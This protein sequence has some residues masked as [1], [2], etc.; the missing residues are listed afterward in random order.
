MKNT[1]IKTLLL[2][3]FY[4]QISEAQEL[5]IGQNQ[6][7][8]S[9]N[10]HNKTTAL[11]SQSKASLHITSEIDLVVLQLKDI[12]K[13]VSLT[14]SFDFFQGLQSPFNPDVWIYLERE[15][16]GGAFKLQKINLK[17]GKQTT[18]INKKNKN[19][20]DLVLKP[21]AWTKDPNKFFAEAIYLDAAEEHEG[22]FIYNI[23]TNEI[24]KLPISF[25]YT[26][27][28]LLSPQRDRF[29]FSGS[30]K[31]KIDHLHDI[32]DHIYE[33]NIE[34]KTTRTII[35]SKGKDIDVLGWN[36]DSEKNKQYRINHK[37]NLSYYL[38]WDFGKENCVSRHGTPGPTGSH[39]PVGQCGF[40][41]PGGHHGYHAIDFATS[42]SGD[43]NVRAS[44]AGTVSFS[45]ISGSLSSGYGR[46]VIIRHSDGTRTYYAH[47]K[48]LLVNQ[49][50]SV[51]KGQVI[52]LEGTTGGS[53][54]D[55]IHFEWRAAGG[56]SPTSGSFV[57]AGQPRQN[58][59]YR[60]QNTFGSQSDTQAPTTSITAVGGNT[61]SSDFT[62]NYLDTDNIGV[63]RRF[64]Q[65][66]E[67]YN[68]N[69]YANRG[70]GFFNDN[71]N[72]FYSGYTKGAGNWA[73]NNGHLSQSNITLDNTK[74][75]TFL[76]Q[77]SGL[78]YLYE[79]SAKIISTSGPKKFGIHIMADSPDQSQRGNSYLIWFS[80]EDNKVRIYETINNQLN[81]RAIDDVTLD[82][83]WANYKITYSPGFGVI[84]VFRNNTS[85]LKWTDTSPIKN[86]S[87]I[88]LRT[89][90]T[91]IELDDL[92]VY[93]FR[94]DNT[95]EIL[96]GTEITKDIRR[97]NGKIKSLVRDAAGNWS[98]PGNLDV[99]ISSITRQNQEVINDT[100]LKNDTEVKIYPNP[101]NGTN[102]TLTY[103]SLQKSYTSISI[104]DIKGS[105]LKSF[106]KYTEKAGNTSLNLSSYF[107]SLKDGTY[108][109]KINDDRGSQ[110]I[111]IIKR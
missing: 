24:E 51:Q 94:A 72:I 13:E 81:F 59:I 101:T 36:I 69:W 20:K 85:I 7:L 17:N 63:T 84:E 23:Q 73:I 42:L 95:T 15:Q 47:N 52:A 10:T 92:K 44:A 83:K 71:F 3:L 91:N 88:S 106:R 100:F 34:K 86:G 1:T 102:L 74:L 82:D 76:S 37:S 75:N 78:P 110:T 30:T 39:S 12:T 11:L 14:T 19:R 22:I 31:Q 43:D 21:I 46:L 96:A 50:Q 9:Q 66:L 40:F 90:K 64:Y 48:T 18:L 57:D 4:V 89:N 79:F 77:N 41:T 62:V 65:V 28:P 5:I 55:H 45:G 35:Q 16:I 107:T 104:I 103:K 29:I 8:Y 56:N 2:L 105:V 32:S 6:Q 109:I 67:K 54:G 53:T 26:R 99:T 38:P 68:D 60:S 80:G 108:F 33:Y 87:S 111:S 93:K 97:R 61:Q 27:T 25:Q 98:S 49:G 70:N 58:Y